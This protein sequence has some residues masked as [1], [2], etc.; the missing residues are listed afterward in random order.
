MVVKWVKKVILEVPNA[1]VVTPANPGRGPTV[2][3]KHVRRVNLV[4]PMIQT[5]LRARH[6]NRATFKKIRAKLPVCRAFPE[7]M[8]MI[9]VQ[10]NAKIV[11]KDNIKAYRATTRVWIAQLANTRM[12]KV[13]SIV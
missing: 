8:K 11:A 4:N 6:A 12:M 2:L 5:L 7:R 1:P 9:R 13:R 10:P 3:A